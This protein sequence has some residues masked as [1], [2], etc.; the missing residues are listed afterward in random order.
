MKEDDY[1][2]D[3][4]TAGGRGKSEAMSNYFM[5]F[6]RE[7]FG[8][9]SIEAMSSSLEKWCHLVLGLGGGSEFVNVDF[10]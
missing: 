1:G 5:K 6:W 9:N 8:G 4:F 7:N 2:V 10:K 3:T